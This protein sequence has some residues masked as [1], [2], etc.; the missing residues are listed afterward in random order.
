MKSEANLFFIPA[1][2]VSHVLRISADKIKTVENRE[3]ITIENEIL[4][5]VKFSD[6]LGLKTVSDK[7][8]LQNPDFKTNSDYHQIIV[9]NH[10]N[11]KIG[12]IV[13]EIMDEHQILIKELGKQL[14][15][16]R[17]ISGVTILGTG[18]IVPVVNVAGL[19]KSSLNAVKT[20]SKKDDSESLKKIYKIL[21]TEDSITSRTLIKDILENAGYSVETAVDGLDGYTKALIGQFDLIVSDVD[22]PRMNGFELT[23]KIRN[24]KK[25][26]ELPI[27]LVTAL[28]SREDRE[29]GIDVG[30]N[31]YIIKNSFDQS[32]LL[33]VVQ[34]L[35]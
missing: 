34:K 7:S 12:F 15:S 4:G 16:V 18:E 28:D 3:T 32:N 29:H 23:T 6:V 31:A 33:E 24:H 10:A 26:G 1:I 5:L 8:N 21:V 25:L 35:L 30:A 22:M 17:N 27:V 19:M 20:S 2:H 9:L 14:K 13:D 11:K